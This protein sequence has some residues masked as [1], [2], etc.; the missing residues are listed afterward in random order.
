MFITVTGVLLSEE[1]EDD[2]S[3][4]FVTVPAF[5]SV[6]T[7]KDISGMDY[8][9]N[10]TFIVVHDAKADEDPSWPRVSL[11]QIPYDLD[12]GLTWMQLTNDNID[13][14]TDREIQVKGKGSLFAGPN[15]LESVAGIPG[16][17]Y[18][19]LCESTNS[20][21]D[22][23][24]ADRIYLAE[25]QALP[26]LGFVGVKI[27]A[28]TNWSSF[29]DTT[30]VEATAV[31]SLS[32]D[33][34]LF[35]W[36]ERDETTIRWTDLTLEPK[37]HI[38]QGGDA[39]KGEF[40]LEESVEYN[41]PIVGL[42]VDEVTGEIYLVSSHDLEGDPTH[43]LP[44]GVEADNGPYRSMT[45]TIGNVDLDT[46]AVT[47]YAAPKKKSYQDGFKGESVA[48]A[49]HISSYLDHD[50]KT[51]EPATFISTDDENYGGTLRKIDLFRVGN[52]GM[53]V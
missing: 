3:F 19:L 16:T 6:Q 5:E 15:D 31:A 7:L 24:V 21:E 46:G 43:R 9:G 8:L 12:P 4:D 2:D 17:M 18:A 49:E 44:A 28:Y 42:D 33:R 41:R 22:T 14:P 1:F 34:Y 32:N 48:R 20:K 40:A 51:A 53:S 11:V 35:L 26:G 37:L 23:P 39:G 38:G 52:I 50:F 13:W 25:A 27:M 30:N 29:A 45:S 47:I 10:G 36:G